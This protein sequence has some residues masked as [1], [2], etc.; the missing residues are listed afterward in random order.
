MTYTATADRFTPRD[1]EVSDLVAAKVSIQPLMV[2]DTARLYEACVVCE[3][4]GASPVLSAS[5]VVSYAD[6]TYY[7]TGGPIHQ[8][9]FADRACDAH[10]PTL[11]ENVR[12][13]YAEDMS[14]RRRNESRA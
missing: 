11:I 12:D 13:R 5:W 10:L 4:V 2:S 6:T 1:I 3:Y 7:A 14:A 8:R 9:A